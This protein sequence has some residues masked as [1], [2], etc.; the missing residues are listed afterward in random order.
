MLKVLKWTVL[1]FLAIAL[2]FAA[3][4][5]VVS[6]QSET[7][8]DRVVAMAWG[9]GK[10]GEAFYGA[11]VYLEPDASGYSV[12]ARVYLGRGN[13]YFYDCGSIGKAAD[14]VEAV[15]KWGRIEFRPDGL[16]IGDYFLPREQMEA[17]R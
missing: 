5:V 15:K 3:G 13:N 11:Q 14:D 7:R 16:H 12:R 17:H 8:M 2:G 6:R 10:Y 4:W 1:A 9:D